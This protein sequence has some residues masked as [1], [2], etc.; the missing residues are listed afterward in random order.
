MAFDGAP[1]LLR[2]SAPRLETHHALIIK[3]QDRSTV[4]IQGFENGVERLLVQVGK[5]LG[6]VDRIGQLIEK[7][8]L[9]KEPAIVFF[10]SVQP[11]QCPYDRDQFIGF[12]GLDQVG[13]RAL[14]QSA[15]TIG[16]LDVEG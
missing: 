6:A 1:I 15:D 14:I 12:N 3:Q 16:A 9:S 13:I 5:P 4:G 2:Q 11:Q 7:V 10:T 8:L